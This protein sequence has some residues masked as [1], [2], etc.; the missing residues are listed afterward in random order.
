NEFQDSQ[1]SIE[2]GSLKMTGSGNNGYEVT[3]IEHGSAFRKS[4]GQKQETTARVRARFDKDFKLTY[5][6]QEQLLENR[7]ID[8]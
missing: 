2:E 4:K 8:E 1:S 6:R 5:F 3:Y 7:F